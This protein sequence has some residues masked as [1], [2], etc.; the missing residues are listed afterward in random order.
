[1]LAL[2][3]DKRFQKN[4]RGKIERFAFEVGVLQD[5]PHKSPRRGVRGKGGKDVQTS[6]AGGPARKKS[7]RD[8]GVTISEVSRQTRERLGVNY[9]TAPFQ[10]KSKA[11]ADILRF[12]NRFFKVVF[13]GSQAKRLENLLQAVVRNPI[14]RGDYGSN[15]PLT[16]RI[17]G[18]DR[19]LIDTAQL[20]RR[21][22][23]R[24]IKK[25]GSRV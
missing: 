7:S 14:L 17:K 12:T 1:M 11:Q 19:L 23:A 24:V 22:T 8:S 10:T 4:V 2:K 25:G 18:F 16:K 20:F 6:Y 3:L 9:L 15:K 5:G 13:G 21:I